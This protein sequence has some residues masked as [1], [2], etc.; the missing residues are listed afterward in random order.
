M[1]DPGC[2]WC[3]AVVDEYFPGCDDGWLC[4][5]CADQWVEM[6]FEETRARFA[7]I[8]ARARDRET[9]KAERSHSVWTVSGGLP[10]L[11]KRRR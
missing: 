4:E 3:G 5:T 7:R 8:E 1:D 10:T 11:G 9:R 6:I 2:A